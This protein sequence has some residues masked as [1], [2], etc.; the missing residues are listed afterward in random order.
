MGLSWWSLRMLRK[1]S[2]KAKLNIITVV[3]SGLALIIASL[4]L[5]AYDLDSYQ[6]MLKDDAQTETKMVANNLARLV[7]DNAQANKAQCDTI[8]KSL[9]HRP[10]IRA[11]ALFNNSNDRVAE[12]FRGPEDL[13]HLP[14]QRQYDQVNIT[15]TKIEIWSTLGV[16]D[17]EKG[18]LY[19]E[20][21]TSSWYKRLNT[22][23]G[24]IIFLVLLSALGAVIASN[25][26][27][28]GITDPIYKVLEAMRASADGDYTNRLEV[29]GGH[30]LGQ[31]MAGYN[32]MVQEIESRENALS[33]AK[34][35]LE[36]RV[37]IRTA[38]LQSE[39]QERKKA[40]EALAHANADLEV[41]VANA[42]KMA[43]EADAA[44][45]SKSEFLA[46]MSH[47]I[48]TPM[49]G[50]LGMTGLLMDTPLTEEQRDFTETIRSSAETLLAIIN[51]ILDFSKIEAGKL[52]IEQVDFNVR[53]CIEEVS[54]LFASNAH[55]KGL[56]INCS[57]DQRLPNMLQGDPV[58]FKQIL[59]NLTSNA[60]KFTEHGEVNVSCEVL[61]EA[62]GKVDL[63]LKVQDTGIGI[64]K[65]RHS[66]I[67]Q[68]FTQAD[69]STT[70]KYG[71]TGLGLAICTQLVGLMHGTIEIESEPEK[72]TCFSVKLTLP[73]SEQQ[74]VSLEIPTSLRG[75]PVLCV[76]DNATNLRILSH[77]LQHWGCQITCVSSGKEALDALKAGYKGKPYKLCILDMA[78]PD[79]D[80]AMT[81]VAIKNSPAIARIPLILLS[82]IGSGSL[83]EFRLKGFDAVLTKPV[84]QA[85]LLR[86]ILQILGTVSGESFAER[87]API[88]SVGEFSGLRVLLAEDNAV[89]QK[90]ATQ[91]LVRLGCFVTAV[92]NG[93][94]ALKALESEE[95]DIVLMDV[96][97]PHMD[98]LEAAKCI[99]SSDAPYKDIT[100]VALTAN[101]MNG[102]RERCIEA[103]MSDYLS[104][105]VKPTDLGAMLEKWARPSTPEAH[106]ELPIFDE[107]YLLA[108]CQ[109]DSETVTALLAEFERSTHQMIEE[110]K[111]AMRRNHIPSIRRLAQTLK[112]SAAAIG[113]QRLAS[114]CE[115]LES[116]PEAITSQQK[117]IQE[118]EALV[119]YLHRDQA[120]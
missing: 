24:L 15:G 87:R 84:R 33:N 82:S 69:G 6:Q 113:A 41:A 71:G 112:G 28:R 119:H 8:L 54:E 23:L 36:D 46:N 39:V 89:N 12:Y 120:A 95:F 109:L 61:G 2:I 59:S 3:T 102:D 16:D 80:G 103:G 86:T 116:V 29:E 64:P 78:M 79:M 65:T 5:L 30:E 17:A 37:R 27:Q 68:S 11:A 96:Q 108:S 94:L 66:A 40:E 34:F 55:E 74:G 60:V 70:R 90:V 4:G 93:L 10:D 85:N 53:T 100:I 97:M 19:V 42:G 20:V 114:A 51:D 62:E 99:R 32:A 101:A 35:E 77:Q 118:H 52:Q 98:G 63:C 56:E 67:F 73:K 75:L 104:K 50:V 9:R 13:K 107:K 21:D 115:F 83:E 31:L 14:T 45:R 76:D 1:L 88:E 26:M 38:E 92:E 81:A 47:E 58:R 111:S 91:I 48:R 110:I 106:E 18:S 117:L 7:L 44:S 25:R 43:S 57:I 22:Y 72:G 105:P 49:N